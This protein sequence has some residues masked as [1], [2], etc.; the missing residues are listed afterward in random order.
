M[1]GGTFG[2]SGAKPAPS[3]KSN[4]RVFSSTPPPRCARPSN[5]Q[6]IESVDNTLKTHLSLERHR[7]RTPP[8][9]AE[10]IP[11]RILALTTAIW[12]N[13]TTHQPGPA[14]SLVAYDR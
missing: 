3:S 13:Q 9:A 6:T 14:R 5:R 11:T 1:S 10:R 2:Q 4:S 7:G 8:G 12:H